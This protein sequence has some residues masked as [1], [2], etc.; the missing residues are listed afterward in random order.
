LIHFNPRDESTSN[1]THRHL[2]TTKNLQAKTA[3]DSQPSPAA[4]K[5]ENQATKLQVPQ[6][7]TQRPSDQ[8]TGR[9]I[10]ATGRKTA[11]H[12]S[13][14]NKVSNRKTKPSKLKQAETQTGTRN[15]V[16]G[17]NQGDII[18]RMRK[19]RLCCPESQPKRNCWKNDSSIRPSLIGQ[20]WQQ[21]YSL[22]N[23]ASW[24]VVQQWYC[25]PQSQ[26]EE[27]Q[28]DDHLED[29]KV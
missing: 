28:E 18:K 19:Q 11:T 1:S 16:L 13:Q 23:I 8:L 21:V 29:Q 17:Q 14:A 5:G 2:Y 9:N 15:R 22:S 27:S 10:I 20:K 6:Q 25:L 12:K 24:A 3:A 4:S 7:Q 26:P